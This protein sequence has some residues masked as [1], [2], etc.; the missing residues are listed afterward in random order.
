MPQLRAKRLEEGLLLQLLQI[1]RGARQEREANGGQQVPRHAFS[2]PRS[3]LQKITTEHTQ[4]TPKEKEQTQCKVPGGS[5]HGDR[6]WRRRL[7]R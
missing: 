1:Q 4:S 5:V 7:A 3:I 2:K 6:I